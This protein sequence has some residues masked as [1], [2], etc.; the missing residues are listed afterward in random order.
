MP[1][2]PSRI[3]CYADSMAQPLSLYLHIPFCTAKCGYCDFNSYAGHDH[4]IPSYVQAL[5][6]EAQLWRSATAGRTVETVFFGGGTPTL[7]PIEEAR[8]IMDGLRDV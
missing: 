3:V 2:E 4:L 6:H 7:L 1:F 8:L 5:V